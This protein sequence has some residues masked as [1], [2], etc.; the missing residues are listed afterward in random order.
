[1]DMKRGMHNKIAKEIEMKVDDN[2]MVYI[3]A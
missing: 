3:M 2:M 1:M